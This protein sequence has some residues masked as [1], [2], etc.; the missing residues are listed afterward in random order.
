M[1]KPL[2]LKFQK[3]KNSKQ[4]FEIFFNYLKQHKSPYSS[5]LLNALKQNISEEEF[6]EIIKNN[7]LAYIEKKS[8]QSK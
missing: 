2:N 4:N 8:S 7:V 5:I 1:K 3:T 6:R